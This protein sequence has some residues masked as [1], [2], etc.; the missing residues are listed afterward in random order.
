MSDNN[1]NNSDSNNNNN[2]SNNENKTT[3]YLEQ[4]VQKYLDENPQPK[5]VNMPVF[6][7]KDM[8]LSTFFLTSGALISFGFLLGIM[9]G[10][11]KTGGIKTTL[12]NAPPGTLAYTAKALF[13]GTLLCFGTTGVA[14]YALK[15]YNNIQTV[16]EF[17]K[18]MSSK[19]FGIDHTKRRNQLILEEERMKSVVG[20]EDQS[21]YD[22]VDDDEDVHDVISAI[23]KPE[24]DI[25]SSQKK[26]E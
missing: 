21:K 18:F 6:V 14:L 25:S 22:N 8:P 26:E 4:K 24:N 9:L 3:S 19:L 15:K 1:S 12:R 10:T 17:G 23:W 7:T 13:G 20:A 11:R 16:D 2:N 5:F